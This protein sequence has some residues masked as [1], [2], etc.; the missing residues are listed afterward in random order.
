[1]CWICADTTH[2]ASRRLEN[3]LDPV[4]AMAAVGG[5]CVAS[6]RI[7]WKKPKTKS[8]AEKSYFPNQISSA[9]K[10]DGPSSTSARSPLLHLSQDPHAGGLLHTLQ[11]PN[12]AS[13]SRWVDEN[14]VKIWT[15]P[16]WNPQDE[17]NTPVLYLADGQVKPSPQKIQLSTSCSP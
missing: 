6:A 12:H 4:G 11:L 15:P 13:G 7:T 2:T 8:D 14:Y 3:K 10:L 17:A 1:M 16:G 9:P 5:N